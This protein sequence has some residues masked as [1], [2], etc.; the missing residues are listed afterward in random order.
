MKRRSY[1]TILVLIGSGRAKQVDEASK[2]IKCFQWV[3]G[4]GAKR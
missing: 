3:L 1:C 4:R 2:E